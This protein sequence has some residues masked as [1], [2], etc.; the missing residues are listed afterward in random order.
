MPDNTLHP[1]SVAFLEMLD[2]PGA[3]PFHTLPL[4]QQ[5]SASEKMQFAF[6]RRA[7]EVAEVHEATMDRT[8]SEGGP[9]RY[10]LYR[11]AGSSL[12][13]A[14]PVLLWFHGG[15][16]TLGNIE[17]YDVA[18][19][20]MANRSGCA[21]MALAYRLAPKHPFPA[22][23]DDCFS[24]IRWVATH[25]DALAIDPSRLAVG[26]DSAGGNLAAVT[27][28]RCRDENGPILSFQML[29]YPSTDQR[30]VSA[31]HQRF[32]EGYLLSQASIR[33]FQSCYLRRDSDYLDWRASPLLAE[34]LAGLPPALVITASHD[35][36][37][38]DSHAYADRLEA[39][40][41]A[42]QRHAYPGMIHGFF[43]LGKAFSDA[44]TAVAEA[45]N[46]L[47][48]AMK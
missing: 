48:N 17:S 42:V 2:R 15:G 43:T 37:V 29:I 18:C 32:A 13:D 26:G 7:P 23:V 34:S 20:E 47:R 22:A 36:L 45:A 27:A 35:P 11:P 46:S 44:D 31:S 39:A 24:A 28:L 14:L 9:L 21:V 38:D 40:G 33:F 8:A 10:R 12:H 41:V 25:A 3:P 19:R 6:R 5:R 16:W 4:D 1:D 30:G